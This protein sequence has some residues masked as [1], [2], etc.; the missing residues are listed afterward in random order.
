MILSLVVALISFFIV[1]FYFAGHLE[2]KLRL[3]YT[4]Y[5]RDSFLVADFWRIA[6]INKIDDFF[7]NLLAPNKLL[8]CLIR[9]KIASFPDGFIQLEKYFRD[10]ASNQFTTYLSGAYKEYLLLHI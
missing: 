10:G 7:Q 9:E 2:C 6:A 8:D 4:S 5:P 1:A 3:P